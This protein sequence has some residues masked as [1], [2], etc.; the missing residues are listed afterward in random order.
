VRSDRDEPIGCGCGAEAINVVQRR[1]LVWVLAI[2]AAMFVVE[3]TAGWLAQST[4]LIAD[5]LDMLADAMVYSVGLYAVGKT[6]RHKARAA[7]LSGAL[8]FSLAIAVLADVVRRCIV[9]SDPEGLW[10]MGIAALALLVNVASLMLLA[11]HRQGEIHMRAMWICTSNDVLVNFAVIAS[12][13]LV[14]WLGSPLPDLVVG[15]L[16]SLLVLHNSIRIMREARNVTFNGKGRSS[17]D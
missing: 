12:G 15:I 3:F 16:V 2:N 6:I 8:E 17:I 10:M 7:M 9:G 14:L 4:G 1:I 11:A 5:S 13:G